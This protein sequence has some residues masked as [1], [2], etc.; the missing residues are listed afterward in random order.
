VK[1]IAEDTKPA[2]QQGKRPSQIQKNT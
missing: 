1:I 2:T